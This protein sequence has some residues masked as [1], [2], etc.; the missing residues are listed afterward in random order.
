MGLL[1]SGIFSLIISLFYQM[2]LAASSAVSSEI[3]L[4]FKGSIYGTD[5]RDGNRI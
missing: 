4:N 3:S 1:I 5:S 2:M